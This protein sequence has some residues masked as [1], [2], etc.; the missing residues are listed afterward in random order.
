MHTPFPFQVR[1]NLTASDA[2]ADKETFHAEFDIT[3]SEITY[4]A[5][6]ALGI[7]PR[8]NPPE[9]LAVL[10]ALR[11]GKETQVPVPQQ[12]YFPRPEGEFM[13]LEQVLLY[14]YDL[15]TVKPD[16]IKY[17]TNQAVDSQQKEKG[18]HILEGGVRENISD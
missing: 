8:N 2:P 9:V 14:Y 3:D 12:C 7:Y 18:E 13:D 15:K 11:A 1:Y 5:G 10:N 4:T 6:D 17:L 16:L